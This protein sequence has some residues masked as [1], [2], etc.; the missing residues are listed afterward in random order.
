MITALHSIDLFSAIGAWFLCSTSQ[1]FVTDYSIIFTPILREASLAANFLAKLGTR[2]IS[3]DDLLGV[4][5]LR[6]NV[7]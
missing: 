2:H 7:L 4:R 6:N 3:A 1:A 5:H